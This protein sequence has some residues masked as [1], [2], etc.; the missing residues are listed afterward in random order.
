M[1]RLSNARMPKIKTRAVAAKQFAPSIGPE[2]RVSYKHQSNPTLKLIQ[3]GKSEGAKKFGKRKLCTFCKNEL[4]SQEEDALMEWRKGVA[5]A[6]GH[7]NPE[8][9]WPK[10]RVE[11]DMKKDS[12][13]CWGFGYHED[14]YYK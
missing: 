1:F 10:V 4:N 6:L 2:P 7:K 12:G 13:T 14:K 8:Y 11:E 9:I 3:G 5:Y